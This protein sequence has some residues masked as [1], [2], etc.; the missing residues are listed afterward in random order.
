VLA[1]ASPRRRELLAWCGV[2]F[3]RVAG[4]AVDEAPRPGEAPR[5]LVLRLRWGFLEIALRTS[6][7][8]TL[9]TAERIC[10]TPDDQPLEVV[11]IDGVETLLLR[12]E[13]VTGLIRRASNA[14]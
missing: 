2:P 8:P 7:A 11:M 12:P 3:E 9:V 10:P 6:T 13:Y 5:D 14:D 4:A 1:S